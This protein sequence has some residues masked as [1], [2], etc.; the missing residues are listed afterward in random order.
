MDKVEERTDLFYRGQLQC[1]T[2]KER[3]AL[4]IS[5]NLLQ[6]GYN[7]L[8]FHCEECE[9]QIRNS[10][11]GKCQI[12]INDDPTVPKKHVFFVYKMIEP[13]TGETRVLCCA[14]DTCQTKA[15]D[16]IT[17]HSKQFSQMFPDPDRQAVYIHTCEVCN[18]RIEK[19]LRCSECSNGS[20]CSKECF[21]KSW[22]VHKQAFHK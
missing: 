7:S 18:K 9:E 10:P 20:Y 1:E 22:P 14:N 16:V 15:H 2:C 5:T 13:M 21:K 4:I 19:R 11:V 3:R 8:Q 12:C 6:L 17:R